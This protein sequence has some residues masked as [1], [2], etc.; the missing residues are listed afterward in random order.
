MIFVTVG[1]T[2]FP[3]LR[4]REVVRRLVESQKR[5][6]LILFQHGATPAVIHK[7]VKNF[8]S[9]SYSRMMR[10]TRNAR[11]IVCHGGP[12]TIF[13]AMECGKKPYVLPRS[14]GFGE[15]VDDH[16]AYFTNYAYQQNLIHLIKQEDIKAIF[17]ASPIKTK[18][19][20]RPVSSQLI[21]YLHSIMDTI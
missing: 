19:R 13:Q 5:K 16:Q 4:M 18:H 3:F 10:Y 9:I 6:E 7:Q 17:Q 2:T 14:K 12:A 11:A 8:P 20:A 15:H 1:T 21:T